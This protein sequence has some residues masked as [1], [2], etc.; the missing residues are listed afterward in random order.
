LRSSGSTWEEIGQ[1]CG[2]T[3]QAALMRWGPR[4]EPPV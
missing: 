1:A 3:R 4:L 2:T